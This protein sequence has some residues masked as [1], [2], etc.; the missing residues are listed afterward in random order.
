MFQIFV[1]GGP[2]ICSDVFRYGQEASMKLL[3]LS[4]ELHMVPALST[5]NIKPETQCAA[6]SLPCRCMCVRCEPAHMITHIS[7]MC[8]SS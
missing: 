2:V 6:I 4:A 8:C 7:A 1:A 3:L 5:A